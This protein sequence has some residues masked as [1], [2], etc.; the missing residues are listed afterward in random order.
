MMGKMNNQNEER[1][2]RDGTGGERDVGGISREETGQ[3]DAA[4]GQTAPATLICPH[5][6]TMLEA[7][8]VGRGDCVVCPSCGKAFIPFPAARGKTDRLSWRGPWLR[9]VVWGIVAVTLLWNVYEMVEGQTVAA[10]RRE[11][12]EEVNQQL[13]DPESEM[14]QALWRY[15]RFAHVTVKMDSA[16][17]VG[18]EINTIDGANRVGRNAR[19]V[20][21]VSLSIRFEWEGWFDKGHTDVQYDFDWASGRLENA[22][23]EDTSA[24]VN[25]TDVAFWEGM[26]SFADFVLDCL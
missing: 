17:V 10:A 22:R 13:A 24:L 18:C 23:I 14:A 12:T 25:I 9:F 6:Q 21:N 15:P 16:H 4:N 3:E 7:E 1:R 8:N 2:E 5:C 19:N 11:L 26:G 20:K